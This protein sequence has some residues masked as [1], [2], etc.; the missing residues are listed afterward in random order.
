MK[1]KA[2]SFKLLPS[3]KIKMLHTQKVA[4]VFNF[5]RAFYFFV[6]VLFATVSFCNYKSA[7]A[8]VLILLVFKDLSVLPK[9]F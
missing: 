4:P 1:K 6:S 8:E 7:Q 2:F 3:Q 9:V 5:P